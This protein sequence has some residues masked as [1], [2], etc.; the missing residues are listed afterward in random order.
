M[1][2]GTSPSRWAASDAPQL[3]DCSSRRASRRPPCETPDRS[4]V[5]ADPDVHLHLYGKA[6][7]RPGR[8]MGHLTCVGDD[9]AEALR[10]VLE[11]RGALTGR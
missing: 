3:D 1:V 4:A 7:A 2:T 10:R 5:L 8:K 6:E 9:S 11:A